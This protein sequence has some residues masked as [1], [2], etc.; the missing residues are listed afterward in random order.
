[1]VPMQCLQ[2]SKFFEVLADLILEEGCSPLDVTSK[3]NPK[4]RIPE[5]LSKFLVLA[6]KLFR[7]DP[8]GQCRWLVWLRWSQS[9]MSLKD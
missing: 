4:H 1:M 7:H 5:K 8:L 3:K 2:P 6:L 9:Q